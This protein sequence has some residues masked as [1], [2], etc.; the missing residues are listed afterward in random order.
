VPTTATAHSAARVV[1]GRL[2]SK[3]HVIT[4]AAGIPLAVILTGGHR[5]DVT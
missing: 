4:D 5:N 2:D 3:H 1:G